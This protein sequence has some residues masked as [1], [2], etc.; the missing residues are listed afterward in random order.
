M[1]TQEFL[2]QMLGVHRPT[3]SVAA[4]MLQEA[5]LISYSRGNI[6]VI[7]RDGLEAAACNCYRLI[8][9]Q[10]VRLLEED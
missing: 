6:Q 2:S 9:D 8:A 4:P 1:L 3:V 10:Y 5:G 7:D